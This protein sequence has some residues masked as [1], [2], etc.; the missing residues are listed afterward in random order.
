MTD[1]DEI[2]TMPDN[3][4]IVT[5]A[6]ND[7]IVTMTDNDEIV[8]QGYLNETNHIKYICQRC[9]RIEL[10]NNND[11]GDGDDSTTNKVCSRKNRREFPASKNDIG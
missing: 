11:T 5:M 1:N 3:D 4:E 2:V 8:F 6:D 7:E 9:N 10:K